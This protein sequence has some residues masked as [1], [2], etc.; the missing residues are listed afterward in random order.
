MA[1]ARYTEDE[2]IKIWREL[3][4]SGIP[5]ESER[6]RISFVPESE[7]RRV[8]I[9]PE[10]GTGYNIISPVCKA[11][12]T[13]CIVHVS[14]V[15]TLTA[16]ITITGWN[17]E[18]PWSLEDPFIWLPDPKD[19]VPEKDCYVLPDSRKLPREQV[20]N[21]RVYVQG[22]LRRGTVIRG[23]L[24]GY[25]MS[26]IPKEFS[27]GGSVSLQLGFFDHTNRLHSQ[28]VR[29]RVEHRFAK[30]TTNTEREERNEI[31][32]KRAWAPPPWIVQ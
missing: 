32:K 5:L 22:G 19:M 21:H 27:Q 8:I 16:K 26:S 17:L 12:G 13:V 25:S 10:V 4:R 23:L 14:V 15:S 3:E 9:E 18:F 29:V 30:V 20:I 24:V 1:A 7:R 11:G 2:L 28:D 31:L 6:D